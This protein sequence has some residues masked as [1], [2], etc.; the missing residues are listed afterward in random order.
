MI[1]LKFIKQHIRKFVDQFMK[2]LS[3]AE[4]EL[5]K[6]FFIKKKRVSTK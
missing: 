3:N 6:A 2:T 4:A 1:M 5:K